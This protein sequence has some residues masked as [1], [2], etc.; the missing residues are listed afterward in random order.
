M[1]EFTKNNIPFQRKIV[2][3][4]LNKRATYSVTKLSKEQQTLLSLRGSEPHTLGFKYCVLEISRASDVMTVFTLFSDAVRSMLCKQTGTVYFFFSLFSHRPKTK[5][6]RL[7]PKRCPVERVVYLITCLNPD[8][9][10]RVLMSAQ[11]LNSET[12]SAQN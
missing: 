2:G 8:K 6:G 1:S 10:S 3:L 11:V 12:R 7:E 9:Q 5:D 4:K